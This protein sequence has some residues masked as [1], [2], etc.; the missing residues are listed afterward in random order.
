MYL[1]GQYCPVARASWSLMASAVR[2]DL[3]ER[4]TVTVSQSAPV[5]ARAATGSP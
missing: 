5:S 2:A 1:D 3:P 4:A